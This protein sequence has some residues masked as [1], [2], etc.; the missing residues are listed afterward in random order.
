MNIK[1]GCDIVDIN[2]ISQWQIKKPELISRVLW[3]KEIERDD[4]EH[5]AGLIAAKE[6]ALKALSL[7]TDHW[8]D[9]LIQKNQEG[10]PCLIVNHTISERIMSS[11]ISIS[12]DGNIALA[13]A[14]ML[15]E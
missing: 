15:I 3:D 12:H 14:V 7:S 13:V 9:I 8:K 1:V 11:N 2:R 4:P 5:I 10:K 6:A